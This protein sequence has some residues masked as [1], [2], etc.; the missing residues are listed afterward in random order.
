MTSRSLPVVADSLDLTVVPDESGSQLRVRWD[1]SGEEPIGF[2][3]QLGID[4]MF[5]TWPHS[6][7]DPWITIPWSLFAHSIPVRLELAVVAEHRT[8]SSPAR[9]GTFSIPARHEVPPS[10][11]WGASA[12]EILVSD[13]ERQAAGL[14]AW[15]DGTI[16]FA[17]IDD[18][19]YGFAAQGSTTSRWR[20]VAPP[21]SHHRAQPPHRQGQGVR[22]G[23][24]APFLIIGGHGDV[25]VGPLPTASRATRGAASSAAGIELVEVGDHQRGHLGEHAYAVDRSRLLMHHGFI[26][27][28]PGDDQA[29][30]ALRRRLAIPEEALVVG[31]VGTATWRKGAD[32]FVQVAAEVLRRR[33][34]LDVHFVWVGAADRWGDDPP[35]DQDRARLGVADRVH[36][37]GEFSSPGEAYGLIDLFLLTSREDPFPLVMLEAAAFGLPIVSF[38]N[39]G[40]TE[41][42]SAGQDPDH[43]LIEVVPALDVDAMAASAIRL[44]DDE[45]ARKDLGARASERVLTHHLT[46]LAAPLRRPGPSQPC[47]RLRG[48]GLAPLTDTAVT[49]RGSRC[50]SGVAGRVLTRGAEGPRRQFAVLGYS[51]RWWRHKRQPRAAAWSSSP[52]T[53]R[54]T[55]SPACSQRCDGKPQTWMSSWSTT[56]PQMRLPRSPGTP[57]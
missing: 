26:D 57:A 44:L 14:T 31:C 52:P 39:G 36:F 17:T 30:R 54:P 23:G 29:A 5:A 53:T 41:L 6:G 51:S 28:L 3:V 4:G 25:P 55:P 48:Q 10:R 35:T 19:T 21:R 22:G 8:G 15:V 1:H 32:L 38:A 40:V 46:E 18:A 37:I 20:V 43:P 42:A 56:V 50:W 49:T 47:V 9:R 45:P 2:K 16:G 33:P 27:P 34:D 12:P 24:G 13:A 7:T 11:S